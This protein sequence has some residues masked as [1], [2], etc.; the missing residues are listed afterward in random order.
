MFR[1]NVKATPHI[2]FYCY[3]QMY[4]QMFSWARLYS[5]YQVHEWIKYLRVSLLHFESLKNG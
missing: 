4:E 3:P 1:L 5:N 2:T